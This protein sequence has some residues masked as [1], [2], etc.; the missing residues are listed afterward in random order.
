MKSAAVVSFGYVALSGLQGAFAVN[1]TMGSDFNYYH[2]DG[3]VVSGRPPVL[4]PL[5]TPYGRLRSILFGLGI[6]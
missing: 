5:F 6:Q 4:C 3:A 1:G 2:E